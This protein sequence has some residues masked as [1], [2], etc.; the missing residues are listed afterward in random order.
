MSTIGRHF[1]VWIDVEPQWSPTKATI[2]ARLPGRVNRGSA[3][4][5]LSLQKRRFLAPADVSL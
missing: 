1:D 4:A 2:A 3:G 5:E